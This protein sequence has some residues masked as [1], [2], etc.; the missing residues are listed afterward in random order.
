MLL[1]AKISSQGENLFE[2]AEIWLDV[3]ARPPEFS[4]VAASV[5]ISEVIISTLRDLIYNK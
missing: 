1:A 2:A 3:L 5:F 4:S